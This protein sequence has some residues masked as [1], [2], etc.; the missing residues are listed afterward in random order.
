MKSLQQRV[1]ECLEE[2]GLRVYDITYKHFQPVRCQ[3][4]TYYYG[5]KVTCMVDR[6]CEKE[7]MLNI[8]KRE[9]LGISDIGLWYLIS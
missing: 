6:S 3:G 5:T 9:I 1:T 2:L 4:S 8:F 7:S